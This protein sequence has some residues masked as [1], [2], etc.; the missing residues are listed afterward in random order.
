MDEIDASEDADGDIVDGLLVGMAILSDYVK[1]R[2]CAKRI[3]IVRM[4]YHYH[5]YS[6]RV[7]VVSVLT[8]AN[9]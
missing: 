9:I 1:K 3:Y 4:R 2:K 6:S 5:C 8:V 7:L